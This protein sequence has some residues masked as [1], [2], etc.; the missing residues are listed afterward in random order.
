LIQNPDEYRQLV[1]QKMRARAERHVRERQSE[2]DEQAR[3][4][5][6]TE[7]AQ[8][9]A[10]QAQRLRADE[11]RQH[12]ATAEARRNRPALLARYK[13]DPDGLRFIVTLREVCLRC[14]SEN[15]RT[16]SDNMPHVL[17]CRDCSSEWLVSHC[18]SCATGLLDSRDPGTPRCKQCGWPKCAVCGACNPQGCST[19]LYNSGHRQRDENK[20]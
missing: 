9:Q 7:A 6:A 8:A 2:E 13:S 10:E 19:N 12:E 20:A 15:V 16:R 5:H 11:I 1:Q 18:W 4:A 3:E 17:V 14:G